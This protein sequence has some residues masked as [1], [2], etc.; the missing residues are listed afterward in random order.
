M[1]LTK[2]RLDGTADPGMLQQPD[3]SPLMA[4]PHNSLM[5]R[6]KL[7][8]LAHASQA[9]TGGTVQRLGRRS[10]ADPEGVLYDHMF[11]AQHGPL[12]INTHA[13]ATLRKRPSVL[14]S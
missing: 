13:Q 8:V 2:L 5:Y 3:S 1:E 4:A 7:R 11:L 10:T 14:G 9:T 12:G 6:C